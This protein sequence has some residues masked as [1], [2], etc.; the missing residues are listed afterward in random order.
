MEIYIYGRHK[1]LSIT[2]TQE[3]KTLSEK[4]KVKKKNFNRFTNF[5][6]NIQLK[7]T[8]TLTQIKKKREKIGTNETLKHMQFLKYRCL[9]LISLFFIFY[10]IIF[11]FFFFENKVLLRS[12][13]NDDDDEK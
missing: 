13:F 9:L 11:F 10:R 6:F 4:M 2:H 3:E 8:Q 5:F 7:N 1:S 12:T